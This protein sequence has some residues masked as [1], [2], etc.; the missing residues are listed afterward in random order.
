MR[1]KDIRLLKIARQRKS[2]IQNTP[3]KA[4]EKAGKLAMRAEKAANAAQ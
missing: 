3:R 4:R 1:R 2:R